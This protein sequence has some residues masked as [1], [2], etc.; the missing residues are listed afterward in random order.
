MQPNDST[1]RGITADVYR[2]TYGTDA[3]S[4]LGPVSRVTIIDDSLPPLFAAT[5]DAP[6]VRAVWRDLFGHS[7]IHL[8]PY[9]ETPSGCRMW[10]GAYVYSSDSRFAKLTGTIFHGPIALHDRLER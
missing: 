6:A 5:D 1:L 8:E 4:E 7:Y 2:S 3:L 9:D 10:G